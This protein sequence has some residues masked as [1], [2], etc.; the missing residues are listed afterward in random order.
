ML[1]PAPPKD[2]ERLSIVRG[3]I[4]GI[5]TD[6]ASLSR[7]VVGAL[8]EVGAC[9]GFSAIGEIGPCV[10]ST[11]DERRGAGRSA[12]CTVFG[13]EATSPLPP[14]PLSRGRFGSWNGFV[15]PCRAFDGESLDSVA[16]ESL[17]LCL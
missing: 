2:E 9:S 6:A 12:S 3:L 7:G 1:E 5:G 15:E 4:A 10:S 14:M 13:S 8:P 17:L 11:V 16:K